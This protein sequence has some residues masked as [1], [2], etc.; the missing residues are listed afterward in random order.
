MLTAQLP[1]QECS[2]VFGSERILEVIAR[3]VENSRTH[4]DVWVDPLTSIFAI[5]FSRV[6]DALVEAATRR[7]IRIRLVT[8]IIQQNAEICKDLSKF[9]IEVCHVDR[10]RASF[11]VNGVEYFSFFSFQEGNPP[12]ELI[13]TNSQAVVKHYQSVF[14]S[15]LKNSTPL[16]DRISY[17]GTRA[18]TTP[19]AAGRTK[20]V[21]GIEQ[22]SMFIVSFL[23]RV[24]A[25]DYQL[26]FVYA[27]ADKDSPILLSNLEWMIEETIRAHPDLE[28]KLITD[29]QKE[30]V[31]YIEKL[32]GLGIEVRHIDGIK[33]RFA[34]SKDEH[35]ET[36]G[37]LVSGLPDEM[38]WSDSPSLI[39]Q[40]KQIFDTLWETGLPAE[41]RIKQ[42]LEGKEQS[43]SKIIKGNQ[44]I[45]SSIE[46]LFGEA[47]RSI[48]IAIGQRENTPS[49]SQMLDRLCEAV[50]GKDIKI[51]IL[52][53]ESILQNREKLREKSVDW[54]ELGEASLDLVIV[55]ESQGI[56]VSRSMG[57]PTASSARFG[58]ALMSTD[59]A[60][61]KSF[62]SIFDA[63]FR[64][65]SLRQKE[66]KA[67]EDA[68]RAMEIEAR[69]RRQ[70]ELLQDIVT[71]DMRNHNQVTLLSAEL[72]LAEL[73]SDGKVR[74]DDS[75]R[76]LA[77][78][79]VSSI[80]SA[81]DLIAKAKGFGKMLGREGK[82]LFSVSFVDSLNRT[83]EIL[84]KANPDKRIVLSIETVPSS[85][86]LNSVRV[87][88]D[89]F[90][91]QVLLN[92]FSNS[93][94]YTNEVEVPIE[95][96]VEDFSSSQWKITISDH[97]IGVPESFSNATAFSRYLSG[98]K[99]TGLGLS[100]VHTLVLEHYKGE[101]RIAPRQDGLRGTVVK[102][103]MTKLERS[104][105]IIE[106]EANSL[107]AEKTLGTTLSL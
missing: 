64:E 107:S 63:L 93:I 103:M 11:G 41:A 83:V 81:N 69:T 22:V 24:K 37:N 56:I 1:E 106:K 60:T 52:S 92:I 105:E 45:T 20:V 40:S 85:L 4:L 101:F 91:D 12:H 17:L 25:I 18:G 38:V 34:F 79:I 14:E 102:L 19:E 67:R 49:M 55:D 7:K 54:Q 36:S 90:F 5:K 57:E 71:H 94:K 95:I 88:A 100:I 77:K 43:I 73:R 98:A 30:N 51:R 29:L 76:S 2:L 26:P 97:G 33:A 47:N 59:Q 35:I 68:L 53:T 23:E 58:L 32:L 10:V 62:I 89:E 104:K 3:T 39:A 74:N 28:A 87:A 48:W 46:A 6:H 72:L 65:S 61:V 44:D 15:L 96:S 21:R 31:N 75:L 84:K 86:S 70:I 99:G 16:E 66:A 78:S 8:E 27:V 9:G 13:Y 82:E 42:I 50:Q 80:E